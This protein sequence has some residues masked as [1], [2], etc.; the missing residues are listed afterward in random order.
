MHSIDTQD[1]FDAE[2]KKPA[3]KERGA[4]NVLNEQTFSTRAIVKQPKQSKYVV[5]SFSNWNRSMEAPKEEQEIP[6]WR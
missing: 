5:L 2:R 6:N 3:E 1:K 4:I